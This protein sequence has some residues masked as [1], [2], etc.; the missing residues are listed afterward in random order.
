MNLSEFVSSRV[1]HAN[2]AAVPYLDA[3]AIAGYVYDGDCYITDDGTT[4]C[5]TIYNDSW[6]VP[7]HLIGDLE[8]MLYAWAVSEEIMDGSAAVV[9]ALA[10]AEEIAEWSRANNKGQAFALA[11]IAHACRAN[12][13]VCH[14]QDVCDAWAFLCECPENLATEAYA[15]M[16]ALV[17]LNPAALYA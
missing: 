5:L 16:R 17:L 1:Y 2:L 6:A 12:P 3:P 11:M 9:Y 8:A 4:A 10:A 14:L 13:S 7:S 15:I